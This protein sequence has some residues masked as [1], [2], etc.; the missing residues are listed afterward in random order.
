MKQPILAQERQVCRHRH[1]REDEQGEQPHDAIHEHRAHGFRL[2]VMRLS[3]GVI[4]LHQVAAGG[5][6][7]K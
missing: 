6:E 2:F 7:Q 1:H 4:R 5:A 3:R